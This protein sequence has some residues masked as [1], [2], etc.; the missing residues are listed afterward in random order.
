MQT[1]ATEADLPHMHRCLELALK[2]RA[3][4][5]YPVGA[6][7]ARGND[8]LGSGV[9]STRRLLDISAHAEIEALRAACRKVGTL[10]L[11]GATVYVH[12]R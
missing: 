6:L 7:V 9:E 2:A 11:R 8:V 4:G 3:S 1:R 12:D 10:D 5:D